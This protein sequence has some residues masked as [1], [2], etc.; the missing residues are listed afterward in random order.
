MVGGQGRSDAPSHPG[1]RARTPEERGGEPTTI[2]IPEEIAS[3]GTVEVLRRL[4]LAVIKGCQR[5][6]PP[7]RTEAMWEDFI[8]CLKHQ[9][10][11]SPAALE[12]QS[13]Y[14]LTRLLF[15]DLCF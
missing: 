12:A 7:N 3:T 6:A 11:V 4:L 2:A 15:L 14:L 8:T 10:L 13:C 5:A 9:D 1:G